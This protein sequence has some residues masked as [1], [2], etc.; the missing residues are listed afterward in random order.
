M[1]DKSFLR[2]LLL[3][4][5]STWNSFRKESEFQALDLSGVNL[6]SV[7]LDGLNLK[8]IDFKGS[9]LSNSIISNCDLSGSD[10]S[11]CDLSWTKFTNIKCCFSVVSEVDLY[12]SLFIE[13][14]LTGSEFMKSNLSS[15]KLYEC[16][17]SQCD[18][19]ASDLTGMSLDSR[20][21]L[22]DIIHFLSDEQLAGVIFNDEKA[23]ENSKLENNELDVKTLE[24]RLDGNNITPFNMSY[25]LLAI[26][27]TY[28]NI[29]YLSQTKCKD[30]DEIKKFIE[31]YYQGVGAEES[32]K[33]KRV[34]EGSIVI[35]FATISA[36]VG[37]LLSISKI[38]SAIGD[39]VNAYRRIS[40]EQT[41]SD[42]LIR[43]TEEETNRL[44]LENKKMLIE[45]NKTETLDKVKHQ[46]ET[47]IDYSGVLDCITFKNSIVNDN[48][49]DL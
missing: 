22:K 17:I 6:R 39:Q 40:I 12:C 32:L 19:R 14:D 8:S 3:S 37:I 49:I 24:I 47:N 4:D 21:Q 29:L 38:I 23:S 7:N 26:E 41:K 36:C 10:L 1:Y 25:L 5:I 11:R 44:K 9:N 48:N 13:C 45:L 15:S 31:P 46:V 18:F 20:K 35:E 42:V 2:N 43:K 34:S 28:N 30:I 33:I 16:N 27:G